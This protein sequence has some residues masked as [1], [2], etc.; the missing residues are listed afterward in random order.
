MGKSYKRWKRRQDRIA[1]AEAAAAEP[2]V[3]S[4]VSPKPTSSKKKST[5]FTKKES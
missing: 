4:K 5:W 2:A 1:A 3:T